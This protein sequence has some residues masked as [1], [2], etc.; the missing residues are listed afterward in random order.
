MLITRDLYEAAARLLVQPREYSLNPL[1]GGRSDACVLVLEVY[2]GDLNAVRGQEPKV[3]SGRYILKLERSSG[4]DGLD[5]RDL[6]REALRLCQN[7]GP[8]FVPEI[9]LVDDIEVEEGVVL[10]AAVY[11][12][13]G[14]SLTGLF[15]AS[16]RADGRVVR[17][18]VKLNQGILEA[19]ADADV[20]QE[21]RAA[22]ATLRMW[23]T[24]RTDRNQAPRVHERLDQFFYQESPIG[25]IGQHV[26]MNPVALADL[27]EQRTDCEHATLDGFIHRDLHNENV[28]LSHYPKSSDSDF[29]I[30]DFARARKEPIGFDQAYFELSQ[31]LL[32]L[33]DYGPSVLLAALEHADGKSS[34]YARYPESTWV[35]Q[36]LV[37][38]RTAC[39]DWI[40]ERHRNWQEDIGLQLLL[41]RVAAGVNWA[42]KNIPDNQC[43]LALAYAGYYARAYVERH[44][45]QVWMMLVDQSPA[46]PMPDDK[47]EGHVL[48]DHDWLEIWEELGRM[49]TDRNRYI[50]VTEGQRNN[51]DFA[52]LAHLP[53]GLV[54]DLDWESDTL[55]LFSNCANLIRQRHN[56]RVLTGDGDSDID[57]IGV[58]WIMSNGWRER[59][60][61]FLEPSAWRYRYADRVRNF[62]SQFCSANTQHNIIIV[63][64]PGMTDANQ[65]H[66]VTRRCVE[67]IDEAFRGRAK[68]VTLGDIDV[69]DLP[70][71][72]PL[73]IR[74]ADFARTLSTK[75]AEQGNIDSFSLPAVNGEWV[76][77]A[78]QNLVLLEDNL[79]VLHTGIVQRDRR[80][81]SIEFWKGRAPRWSEVAANVDI[82]RDIHDPLRRKID[83]AFEANRTQ[84]ILVNS[85][86][87]SGA[88]TFLCRMAWDCREA[89][90]TVI[91]KL[92]N[93]SLIQ[94]LTVVHAKVARPLLIFAETG[95]LSENSREELYQ[96]L[97]NR[98][99]RFILVY[100]RRTFISDQGEVLEPD[101]QLTEAL[102]D[103]RKTTAEKPRS[104]LSLARSMG[105]EEAK[106]FCRSFTALTKD[107]RRIEELKRITFDDSLQRYRTPFFYGLITFQREFQ[108]INDYV[109]SHVE[110]LR[111]HPRNLIEYL[112]VVTIYSNM[113]VPR[114]VINHILGYE[115]DN[116]VPLELLL[117]EARLALLTEEAGAYR[118]SH[119]VVAEAVLE[120]LVQKN[121]Q[122]HLSNLAQEIVKKFVVALSAESEYLSELFQE[123]F[124][125]RLG[126]T[127]FAD[128]ERQ[129]FSPLIEV[130][131]KVDTFYGEKIFEVLTTQIPKEPH[132]WHHRGRYILEQ[133]KGDNLDRAE[134]YL[135]RAIELS[136]H[137]SIHHHQL[138]RI[139]RKRLGRLMRASG[140]SMLEAVGEAFESTIECFEKSRKLAPDNV[141]AY[142]THA[143]TILE[144]AKELKVRGGYETITELPPEEAR[145]VQRNL[146][147]VHGLLSEAETLYAQLDNSNTYI[148]S[149][150]S[151]LNELMGNLDEVVRS[152]ELFNLTRNATPYSRRALSYAYLQ[153]SKRD[154]SKLSLVEVYRIRDNSMQNIRSGGASDLD[155]QLWFDAKLRDE[156]FDPREVEAILSRWAD[157][158]DS[159][160][161]FLYRYA[162]RFTMWMLGELSDDRFDEDIEQIMNRFHGNKRMSFLWLG[163]SPSGFPLVSPAD[164]G[165]WD[166]RQEKPFFS[167]DGQ[168]KLTWVSGYIGERPLKPQ[169]GE[170]V[171]DGKVRAF[172]LPGAD[173]P[174][175][176]LENAA[177]SFFLSFS[178][179][180]LRAW[181]HVIGDKS[182]LRRQ[183][184]IKPSTRQQLVQSQPAMR[185]KRKDT[186]AKLA[187]YGK[188]IKNYACAFARQSLEKEEL[189]PLSQIE[190][191][192][193]AA[194]AFG[195]TYE[196]VVGSP[197]VDYL[198]SQPG[199]KV[200]FA[201]DEYKV[202]ADNSH[203]DYAPETLFG[204]VTK[205]EPGKFGFVMT[206]DGRS[207][208]FKTEW[209]K[210]E[211]VGAVTGGVTVAFLPQKRRHPN[212]GNYETVAK[213]I[214]ILD[215]EV[216]GVTNVTG[217]SQDQLKCQIEA[218][219][220]DMFKSTDAIGAVL[221]GQD[222]VTKLRFAFQGDS[223]LEHYL[224]VADLFDYVRDMPG[225]S[226]GRTVYEPVT[227]GKK[228]PFGRAIIGD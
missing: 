41:A 89:Y 156:D 167:S 76:D 221:T 159:W 5:E 226:A 52:A 162:V 85:S 147:E 143:Q 220:H 170:L 42:N 133:H 123:M 178:V 100:F 224:G 174:P 97:R 131:T 56:L 173:I 96:D 34:Y 25:R 144:V 172:F 216:P 130:V 84:T 190:E 186:P 148:E 12:I 62:A 161:P 46:L 91:V 27:V 59:G 137:D 145:W 74:P 55:G 158:T 8:C 153:R 127:G 109:K 185:G 225:V 150:R 215:G 165:E 138:G 3:K 166:R 184:T 57:P 157:Y 7:A 29:W 86:P 33:S 90:P 163:K 21:K 191:T 79:H 98:N 146:S 192:L 113:S 212:M 199:L 189:V 47:T 196:E 64:L 28:I 82:K 125:Y 209:I 214:Q 94:A 140:V 141:Y 2:G 102:G 222:L 10:K 227:E 218:A 207:Y 188:Q 19:W 129:S 114:K 155:Y 181:R 168:E 106:N 105:R 23:L 180:G 87:G 31:L 119:Q 65:P 92:S 198:R 81:N 112:A 61:A 69:P 18:I 36:F 160:R 30:I 151:A 152:W 16:E 53:F 63:L 40:K 71:V 83:D 38:G 110:G 115:P 95:V 169:H 1:Q 58:N 202:K 39:V 116:E 73:A 126:I 17:D 120:H 210:R 164:L 154:W 139:R 228:V 22:S 122:G 70:T 14:Q 149:C 219:V 32:N 4:S 206:A 20:G 13:A 43:D 107:E 111:G 35:C 135:E 9:V 195:G 187:E 204:K 44:L 68:I 66:Q 88:T 136:E 60:S 201:D 132:F 134:K 103:G 26:L 176:G 203:E 50:L 45:H 72:R 175:G 182:G 213:Q 54:F 171:I 104:T 99:I 200:L 118:L 93:R 78:E 142:V 75:F 193:S 15:P 205:L 177:I 51:V 80:V 197:L 208:Y 117:G 211:S 183:A 217:W 24:H 179:E 124:V 101:G 6:H 108:K 48:G 11:E 121:W 67:I 37:E 194:F 223:L 128:N 77:I 49:E